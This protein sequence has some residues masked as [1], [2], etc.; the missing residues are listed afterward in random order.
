[1]MQK[2]G[3]KNIKLIPKDNIKDIISS[4]VPNRIVEDFVASYII[5]ATK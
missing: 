4:W 3:L 5:E 1:M 2:A